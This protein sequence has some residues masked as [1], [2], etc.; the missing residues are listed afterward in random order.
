MQTFRVH[1]KRTADVSN[2]RAPANCFGPSAGYGVIYRF[3]LRTNHHD[4]TIFPRN[5]LYLTSGCG[6]VGVLVLNPNDVVDRF[7]SF[8]FCSP[9]PIEMRRSSSVV[10]PC[11]MLLDFS[12]HLK[13][14]ILAIQPTIRHYG[15]LE[16]V[17]AFLTHS[18]EGRRDT[19]LDRGRALREGL[20]TSSRGAAAS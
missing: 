13:P 6:F 8:I 2:S 9:Y 10:A 11:A 7:V 3:R 20:L 17:R 14:L 16:T 18:K 15:S 1:Q 19:A 4:S 12:S 5:C